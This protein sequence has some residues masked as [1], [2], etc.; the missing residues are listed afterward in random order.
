MATIRMRNTNKRLT[1]DHEVRQ[2]LDEQGVLYEHW[3]INKLDHDLQNTFILSD[4][5][6]EKILTTFDSE[7]RSLANRRGYKEWDLVAL[8][9]ATPNLDELL[10][11]FEQVHVHT[12]DE[13]R[14]ITA[15]NGI[16]TIKGDSG[17]FDVELSAGD[18]IS[19]PVNVPHF[20]TLMENRQVVA[21]R[22]FIDSSGWVAHPYHDPDFKAE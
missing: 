13:V 8:S 17:Y 6:K 12:E 4:E 3:D 18:V 22:L 16:F 19:V 14:A 7:I 20:F 15:G 10:K 2:F 5:E 21:V 9:N 1:Q 11:K